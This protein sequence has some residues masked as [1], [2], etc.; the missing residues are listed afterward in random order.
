MKKIVLWTSLGVA[1]GLVLGLWTAGAFTPPSPPLSHEVGV[2][3][4]DELRTLLWAAIGAEGEDYLRIRDSILQ[5]GDRIRSFLQRRPRHTD[6]WQQQVMCA[7]LLERLTKPRQVS[8]VI[9]W[10][11][12]VRPPRSGGR[13]DAFGKPLAERARG[14][15]MFLVEKIWKGNE[16]KFR[17]VRPYRDGM[18]AAYALGLL[19]EK[20]AFHPL[21]RMLTAVHHFA[22][23]DK[24][25]NAALAL[26]M[27]GDRRAVPALCH[28]YLVY[29]GHRPGSAS[30]EAI[31]KCSPHG[32]GRQD[33]RWAASAAADGPAREQLEKL[34]KEL[35][36]REKEAR[37]A[38]RQRKQ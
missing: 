1:A 10:A 3:E 9:E 17:R 31:L 2:E 28:A 23:T 8:A 33:V 11:K 7:I 26:G 30:Y 16:L 4:L 34:K 21:I 6:P 12:G 36:R 24:A 22:G 37:A 18:W 19:R 14:T 5:R 15:P 32:E 29:S 13:Y 35:M 20:R 38:K 27:L 25:T